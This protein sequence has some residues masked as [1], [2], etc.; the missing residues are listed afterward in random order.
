MRYS[1]AYGVGP[2]VALLAVHGK[3]LHVVL[4]RQ[5]GKIRHRERLHAQVIE[6]VVSR[7]ELDVGEVLGR[8]EDAGDLEAGLSGVV[9]RGGRRAAGEALELDRAAGVEEEEWGGGHG[10]LTECGPAT[11][12]LS[13]GAKGERGHRKGRARLL[14]LVPGTEGLPVSRRQ[15]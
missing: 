8:L 2:D 9:E 10:P 12:H 13:Y 11:V 15:P 5:P 4:K 14:R 3:D 7:E 6:V 1:V